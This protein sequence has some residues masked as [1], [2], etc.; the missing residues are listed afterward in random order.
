[1]D[2]VYDN[3]YIGDLTALSQQDNVRDEGITAIVRLDTAPRD[4]RWANNFKLLDAPF[5]DGYYV[6]PEHL[7]R[8][9]KFIHNCIDNDETV[10]VHC[11]EGI[12]RSATSVIAYLIEYESMTLS[13][14][15]VTIREGRPIVRPH[16]MLLLSLLDTYDLPYSAR[17]VEKPNFIS[18]LMQDS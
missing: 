1:M 17:Q 16:P 18:H 7:K 3:L 6:E 10:L 12:S 5:K 15:F 4:K 2:W 11:A 8:I 9:T 13:E 14:A